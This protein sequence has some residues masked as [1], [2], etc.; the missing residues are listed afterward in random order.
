MS[1]QGEEGEM[2]EFILVI[3]ATTGVFRTL[4]GIYDGAFLVN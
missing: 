3:S 2:G 1:K 4:P